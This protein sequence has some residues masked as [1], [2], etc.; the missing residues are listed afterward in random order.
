MAEAKKFWERCPH[1]HLRYGSEEALTAHVIDH[2][3][4][5]MQE[6]VKPE[7][8]AVLDPRAHHDELKRILKRGGH[9]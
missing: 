5:Y 9:G 8:R 2:R 7:H 6:M 1:C 3:V 4:K